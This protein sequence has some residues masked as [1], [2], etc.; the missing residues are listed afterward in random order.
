MIGGTGVGGG[1]GPKGD[2]GAVQPVRYDFATAATWSTN[3]NLG[4]VPFVS[5]YL[6]NGEKI[7]ADVT[8]T[9]SQVVLTHAAPVAGFCLCI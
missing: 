9:I 1:K 8:A 4:R 3:H 6:A 5:A 2:D 7:L